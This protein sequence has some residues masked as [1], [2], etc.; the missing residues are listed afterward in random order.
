MT[1]MEPHAIAL[2]HQSQIA[3]IFLSSVGPSPTRRST[4]YP[5][6][7]CVNVDVY[8]MT[9]QSSPSLYL[10]IAVP[11]PL[12]NWIP[13]P[14]TS[15]FPQLPLVL[16]SAAGAASS[17]A[18]SRLATTAA[19][20]LSGPLS[21]LSLS[22][23]ARGSQ[24]PQKSEQPLSTLPVIVLSSLPPHFHANIPPPVTSACAFAAPHIAHFAT[25]AGNSL[26]A[27]PLVPRAVS[28][29]AEAAC[30]L[31]A[32]SLDVMASSTPSTATRDRGAALL[33]GGRSPSN[34]STGSPKA[35]ELRHQVLFLEHQCRL[36]YGIGPGGELHPFAAPSELVKLAKSVNESVSMVTHLFLWADRNDP[37]AVDTFL[38][39]NAFTTLLHPLGPPPPSALVSTSA[40][41]TLAH[42]P[43]H[44]AHSLSQCVLDAIA[45]I[46]TNVTGQP[47]LYYLLSHFANQALEADYGLHPPPVPPISS[48]SSAL[49]P[50]TPP[51]PIPTTATTNQS[52]QRASWS[53]SASPVLVPLLSLTSAGARSLAE[54]VASAPAL[55]AGRFTPPR[56]PLTSVMSNLPWP[57][58]FSNGH[59]GTHSTAS[60]PGRT[61]SHLHHQVSPARSTSNHGTGRQASRPASYSHT[62]SSSTSLSSTSSSSMSSVL[63]AEEIDRAELAAHF[64]ALVRAIANRGVSDPDTLHTLFAPPPSSSS[65]PGS[66]PPARPHS[67]FPLLTHSL[68]ALAMCTDPMSRA[69]LTSV[70]IAVARTACA[71]PLL[72]HWMVDNATRQIADVA[73][74]ALTSGGRGDHVGADDHVDWVWPWLDDVIGES[75]PEFAAC[76]SGHLLA[77]YVLPMVVKMGE[78]VQLADE[79]LAEVRA[80]PLVSML[81]QIML[82]TGG[83][84][85]LAEV[86]DGP[87]AW[88]DEQL[89]AFDR[90]GV[91]VAAKLQGPACELNVHRVKLLADIAGA[92]GI[93]EQLGAMRTLLAVLRHPSVPAQLWSGRSAGATSISSTSESTV[94]VH[95]VISTTAT[96]KGGVGW[97]PAPVMRRMWLV[98][99]ATGL[100][101]VDAA[102][103]M[104]PSAILVLIA[105]VLSKSDNVHIWATGVSIVFELACVRV[106]GLSGWW[107]PI[108]VPSVPEIAELAARQIERLVATVGGHGHGGLMGSVPLVPHSPT[109]RHVPFSSSDGNKSSV[110]LPGDMLAGWLAIWHVTVRPL[111][112]PPFPLVPRVHA[113]ASSSTP[114]PPSAAAS[115]RSDSPPPGAPGG[116]GDSSI[117]RHRSALSFSAA[118]GMAPGAIMIASGGGPHGL[119]HQHHPLS[120]SLPNSPPP[121]PML[122]TTT[123]SPTRTTTTTPVTVTASPPSVVHSRTSTTKSASSSSHRRTGSW[124]GPVSPTLPP[125][126]PVKSYL[127]GAAV[128]NPHASGSGLGVGLRGKSSNQGKGD[129][130]AGVR[131]C[132]AQARE[133]GISSMVGASGFG[134]SVALAGVDE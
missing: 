70:T 112:T 114:P 50:K 131:D 64:A 63:A 100:T 23:A 128:S 27:T 57:S 122:V 81:V 10:S 132:L 52:T 93:D 60:S 32:Q 79:I 126:T 107:E 110:C 102:P 24:Q 40:W 94:G 66:V 76:L 71:I 73:I 129:L 46:F 104:D 62:R 105:R 98:A 14:G 87:H 65:A 130:K 91:G 117:R 1:R 54:A 115:S 67:A 41:P 84:G 51:R 33:D 31:L 101:T 86:L 109:A 49:V 133:L 75:P 118:R 20:L 68:R 119:E 90:A 92:S 95:T 113:I 99:Q 88:Y 26:K 97:G 13:S 96:V 28:G 37:V 127:A 43:T 30:L 17:S 9:R 2:C 15:S 103:G 55:V 18:N 125:G 120:H 4:T 47:T 83:A 72:A 74:S 59:S 36:L 106:P 34:R 29:A 44:I 53:Q 124:A 16:A 19:Y 82:G 7:H 80:V 111:A 5:Q 61:P 134:K 48:N 39:L 78:W 38:E 108:G 11:P 35:D 12:S 56:S 58:G 3:Q 121:M 116:C 42:L 89:A 22:L 69:A 123:A 21:Q 6:V 45:A 85:R 8:C 77:R 25:I